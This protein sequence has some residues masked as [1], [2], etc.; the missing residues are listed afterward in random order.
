MPV[1]SRFGSYADIRSA[2]GINYGLAIEFIPFQVVKVRM[3][4]Q[5]DQWPFKTFEI[6]VK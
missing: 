4:M 5:T 3:Y 6:M 2:I 1:V